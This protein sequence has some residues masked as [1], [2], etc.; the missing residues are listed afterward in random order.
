MSDLFYPQFNPEPINFLI[1]QGGLGDTI[2]RIP[3]INY[4]VHRHPHV[5]P[6]LWIPDY[7][8]SVAKNVF[9]DE[10]KVTVMKFSDNNLYDKN[11]ASR[12]AEVAWLNNLKMHMTQHAMA[13]LANEIPD[14]KYWNY[15]KINTNPIQV[16]KFNLPDKFVV[17]AIAYTASIRKFLP[18]YINQITD[19]CLQAGYK[20]IFLGQE[21]TSVGL[22]NLN[23]NGRVDQTID[24]SKGLNL[25]NK[26]SLLEAA[27]IISKSK[28]LIGLDSG[29]CHLAA[30]TDSPVVCGYTSVDPKHRMP[31]R[32]G[33]M[34]WNWYNVV[35]PDD[36]KEKFF[37]SRWDFEFNVDF[38]KSY[39][40]N[41][42][43][44]KSLKPELWIEQLNKIL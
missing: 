42:D 21:K 10:K 33:E 44:I 14:I 8:H 1:N 5:R 4:I 15:L 19:Y 24:F 38:T 26:T 18:E 7:F 31:V 28:C 16:K 22:N 9:A 34:G 12:A 2:A 3:A 11:N 29:L 40:G 27:K 43:L 41:D 37:Q 32:H 30:M 6:I 39:F 35:P 36:Q 13:L 25:I 17:I 20:V 23:I